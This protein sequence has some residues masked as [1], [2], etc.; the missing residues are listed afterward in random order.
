[1]IFSKFQTLNSSNDWGQRSIWKTSLSR[2][3]VFKLTKTLI[4]KMSSTINITEVL[5]WMN[6]YFKWFI[7]EQEM[8]FHHLLTTR[9][10]LWWLKCCQLLI[11]LCFRIFV[12]EWNGINE[13]HKWSKKR[14]KKSIKVRLNESKTHYVQCVWY[15]NAHYTPPN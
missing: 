8:H 13:E 2:M 9:F 4:S 1:M 12:I 5:I 10:C 7:A 15:M 14:S 11:N 6:L 3:N